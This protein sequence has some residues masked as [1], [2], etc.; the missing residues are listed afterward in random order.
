MRRALVTVAAVIALAACSNDATSVDT[1]L[2]DVTSPSTTATDT[3]SVDSEPTT[4]ETTSSVATPA[5]T[6]DTTT[7]TVLSA[8]STRV[9]HRTRTIGSLDGAVDVVERSP[10]DG[11]V[12]VVSRLGTV[13]RWR[14]DGTRLETVLDV[15][16][17]TTGEGERGLLGLA[18]RRGNSGA[19][20]AY[21][22]MTDLDGNTRIMRHSV[23]ADGEIGERGSLILQIEQPYANHN[24]GDLRFGPDGMLYIATGD[25]GSAGD[26]ERR[27]QDL[28]SLL[29]KVLR[30]DPYTGGYRVPADNPFIGTAGARPEIWS[31]GLRNPWR[32]TIDERG[33]MWLADVGQNEMEEV[34]VARPSGGA[35][36]GRGAD[37]GWSAWEGTRRYNDDL[38]AGTPIDPV[39]EYAHDNGRCSVSGGAVATQATNPGRSGWFFYGD[40][41]S[42]EVWSAHAPAGGKVTVERVATDLGNVS[43]VRATS[44]AMWV[45]TVDGDVHLVTTT[46]N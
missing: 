12:Y 7:T 23:S 15:S 32:F 10:A 29:G 11:F 44:R 30:I 5:T 17:L 26:P 40:Y 38:P 3:T 46:P 24:G 34:S 27:A 20:A 31:I 42:G 22:N 35:V 36:G 41:C 33:E 16:S 43:S 39:L 2:T 6:A 21:V 28:T 14:H 13:E 37:F 4:A 45:T 8:P 1:T 25:G 18:F 19:W 9:T